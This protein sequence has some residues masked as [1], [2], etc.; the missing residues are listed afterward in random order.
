MDLAKKELKTIGQSI[1]KCL[2]DI[3]FN[4]IDKTTKKLLFETPSGIVPLE[5]LSDGYQNMVGW[6]GDL[7]YHITEVFGK[8]ENPF[9]AKGILLVDEL[10]VHL[11]PIWQRMLVS[12]LEDLLPNFQIIST[13]NAPL[14]AQQVPENCLYYLQR[15]DGKIELEAFYGNPQMVRL[16]QLIR[17]PAFGLSTVKSVMVEEKTKAYQLAKDSGAYELSADLKTRSLD[18]AT[19][20]TDELT[21]FLKD[22]PDLDYVT[23]DDQS[24]LDLLAKIEQHLKS[25]S[26]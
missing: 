25:N 1:N 20:A 11:H 12:Y 17:M 3:Q 23:K 4:S 24:Q 13:T 5:L 2:P 6:F 18:A 21:G 26:K 8:A 9:S 16:E 15:E 19:P 22:V 14:T 10:S 7:L